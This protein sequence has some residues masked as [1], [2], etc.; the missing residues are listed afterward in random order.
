[1]KGSWFDDPTN[2]L[3]IA[4]CIEIVASII[5][6]LSVV[7]V[8]TKLKVDF[9]TGDVVSDSNQNV[10]DV[11][12]YIC[13]AIFLISFCLTVWAQVKEHSDDRKLRY[14]MER[15]FGFDFSDVDGITEEEVTR[16]EKEKDRG[17]SI[18]KAK[19]SGRRV[20][21]HVDTV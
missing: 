10:Q 1:M 13:I 12:L 15:H 9:S 16:W 8:H 17:Y 4:I 21:S 3:L 19:D 5:L 11:V 14:I 6:S 7:L 2:I 20:S 18:R